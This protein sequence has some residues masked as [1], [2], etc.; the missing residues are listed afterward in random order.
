MEEE[1]G[2]GVARAEV[3]TRQREHTEGKRTVSE[4]GCVLASM[5]LDA[6]AAGEVDAGGEQDP[7]RAPVEASLHLRSA[8]FAGT[9]HGSPGERS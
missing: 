9:G 4:L 1:S 7:S 3:E 5:L 6:L 8:V 2:G